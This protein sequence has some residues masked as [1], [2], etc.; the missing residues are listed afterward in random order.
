ML[1]AVSLCGCSDGDRDNASVASTS[2][3]PINGEMVL[4]PAGEFTMGNNEGKKDNN[5]IDLRYINEHPEHTL[6]LDAFLIDKYEV[7]RTAYKR[8][9]METDYDAP[10]IW[11]QDGYG[12][13]INGLDNVPIDDVRLIASEHF[14]LD[15]DTTKMGR[16][17]LVKKI[18]DAQKKQDK[19][20]VT[21]VAW[22]D[23][24]SYCN[25]AGKRLPNEA[26]WEKAA[27]GPKG[28]RY[29]WGDEWDSA[30]TNTGENPDS[31]TAVEPVG[32]YPNDISF[33]GIYDMAG[34]VSEWV[35]DWYKGYPGS[36]WV[37]DFYGD[38]HK[39]MRGGGAAVGHNISAVMFRGSRRAHLDP[40]V[41]GTDLG[42]R[43][44][45]NVAR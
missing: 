28:R 44:V 30:K 2:Q 27:R 25:W 26:E 40:L 19:L 38:I 9:V 20:P 43:C 11:S 29:P 7:T 12:V 15:V 31:E 36:T 18:E 21:V 8:F 5:Q 33:Y 37:S 6:H 10:P 1:L 17:E 14:K 13:W 4:I 24:F 34:N 16:D 35:D 32:S 45:R 23:A 42:F 22:Y 39:V 3:T 41:A